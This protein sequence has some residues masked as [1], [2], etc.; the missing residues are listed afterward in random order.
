MKVD[1]QS[2]DLTQ[3]Y[4][5][6]HVLNGEIVYL[7]IPKQIGVKW[8][9]ETKVFRSSVWDSNGELI[10]AGF[11][12]FTN[13]GEAPDVFP[14]PTS[15][16]N[17]TIVE[18]IDGSLLIVS[19]WK[20]H[21][22]LRTRGT[23]D[24]TQLDNGHELEIFKQTILPNLPFQSEDTWSVSYLFEW[25]SPNQKIILNYGDK[26]D[27]YL[28]GIVDHY[29]YSLITQDGLNEF[30]SYNFM[31]RPTTYTFS[32]IED[33]LANVEQWKGKEGVCVYSN[34]DQSIHKVKSA[35]YLTL[36]HMKSELASRE[37][38]I[39]VW[40]NFGK[41]SYTEFYEK[42]ETQFD[43]ELAEQIRGDIS[44]IC[45]GWKEVLKIEE[46]MKKFLK[47]QVLPMPT[48]KLQAVVV[49]QSYG[50][51]NRANFLFKLLDGKTLGDDD[52]KKLL[53]QVLKNK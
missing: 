35:W 6:E 34:E 39:D 52:Y 26:P 8:T 14:L 21:F 31:K 4:V 45:D 42:V 48:R 19:K 3:F 30:A 49:I 15:L 24:A 37:K 51:T 22:I 18:K 12:K 50:K 11:S 9:K 53:Y 23:V 28:V 38:V 10:S 36:H 40:F 46:G 17:A 44:I 2:I 1:L 29:D 13:W 43:H 32:T 5:N 41:P 33:L 16:K 25:V 27:W 47:E 7:V 20:G